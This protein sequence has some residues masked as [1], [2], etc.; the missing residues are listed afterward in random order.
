MGN[1][2]IIYNF[3]KE[4]IDNEFRIWFLNGNFFIYFILLV[5][6]SRRLST[7]EEMILK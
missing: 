5:G 2:I 6:V 7:Q 1:D 3:I 4:A